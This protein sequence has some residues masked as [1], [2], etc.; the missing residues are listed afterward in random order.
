MKVLDGIGNG[1]EA[2]KLAAVDDLPRGRL[3]PAQSHKGGKAYQPR[4]V[5][6]R[7][8]WRAA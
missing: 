6:A 2:R 5:P 1:L 8:W 3:D 7:W 4:S